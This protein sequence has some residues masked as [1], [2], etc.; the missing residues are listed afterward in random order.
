MLAFVSPID[1]YFLL[2]LHT[3]QINPPFPPH[4]LTQSASWGGR[5]PGPPQIPHYFILLERHTL[6]P[7]FC[8][9]CTLAAVHAVLRAFFISAKP[10]IH[11]SLASCWVHWCQCQKSMTVELCYWCFE[12]EH[13]AAEHNTLSSRFTCAAVSKGAA[14]G[15]KDTVSPREQHCPSYHL[16]KD[17]AHWPHVHWG[18]TH[19]HTHVYGRART[20]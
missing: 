3:L 14:G 1:K 13:R 2:L 15:Q 5:L 16:S 9:H 19:E 8:L 7:P 17:A 10:L 12:L 6:P 4:V 11:G 20:H 18:H